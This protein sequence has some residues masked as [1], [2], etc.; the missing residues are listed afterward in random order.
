MVGTGLREQASKRRGSASG[1]ADPESMGEVEI[2]Q[3]IIR[4]LQAAR[5]KQGEAPH[6][7]HICCVCQYRKTDNGT[8]AK[9]QN[10][11]SHSRMHQ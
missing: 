3:H 2:W 4:L 11:E 7:T 1:G 9:Q 10:P 5:R 6:Q 8:S